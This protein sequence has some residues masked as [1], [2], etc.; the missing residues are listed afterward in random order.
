MKPEESLMLLKPT[1]SIPHGGGLRVQ[2]DS[3]DYRVMLSWI[4]SGTM[5]PVDSDV[6]IQRL[7]V[8]PG[9]VSLKTGDIQQILVRAH[10]S[11]GHTEDVTR[12]VKFGTTDATV[13]SVDDNGKVTVN[14]SGETAVTVWYLSLVAFATIT[15]PYQ[16]KSQ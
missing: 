4:K 16:G 14:G 2:K 6:R 3:L 8:L 7:E 12:W 13:A 1:A 10:F 5:P 15:V 9:Q 11:D